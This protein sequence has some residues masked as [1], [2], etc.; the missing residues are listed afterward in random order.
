MLSNIPQKSSAYNDC[1]S[2]WS[3][4]DQIHESA[5]A[6]IHRLELENQKLSTSLESLR[7]DNESMN[8][9]LKTEGETQARRM[10][11]VERENQRLAIKIVKLTDNSASESQKVIELEE[12][13][14]RLVK[15]AD[16]LRNVVETV[17]ENSQRQINELE[18]ENSSLTQMISTLRERNQKS[19]DAKLKELE[20]ENEK[21]SE[22]VRDW[23]NQA[24]ALE[25]ENRGL[26]RQVVALQE[27]IDKYGEI[28][29]E[30]ARL[31]RQAIE[32][33]REIATL[34]LNGERLNNI[35]KENA[36]LQFDNQKLRK[37]LAN[38]ETA[39]AQ[40]AATEE[41]LVSLKAE[42]QRLTRHLESTKEKSEKM[43]G[44][45][46][47]RKD[48]VERENAALKRQMEADRRKEVR[49]TEAETKIG[50][51]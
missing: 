37:D 6:K 39:A 45:M 47:G 1:S 12:D 35:E 29:K 36:D 20:K 28:E 27:A 15:D 26:N 16:D 8:A 24:S 50:Q 7:K 34:R 48:E 43:L 3:L 44:E 33:N 49:A 41:A 25:G 2:Q 13:K 5:S 30:N 51:L 46:E 18:R 19:E 22:M 9:L 4:S 31:G 17:R 10:S 38:A 14:I 32:L 11:E 21:Y 42:N 40:N 23:R